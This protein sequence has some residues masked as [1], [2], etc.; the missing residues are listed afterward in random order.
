MSKSFNSANP[1][2]G[3]YKQNMSASDYISDK[4]LK[5]NPCYF[6]EANTTNLIVNLYTSEDLR[7]ITTVFNT[8]LELESPAPHYVNNFIDPYGQLFGNSFCGVQN[9]TKYIKPNLTSSSA[10]SFSALPFTAFS[11]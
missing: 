8:N 11:R 4:K 7:H 1:V 3:K 2:F 6:K 5:C 9:Y 10:S